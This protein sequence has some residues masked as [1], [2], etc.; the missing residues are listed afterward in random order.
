MRLIIVILLSA[1]AA[2]AQK[3]SVWAPLKTYTDAAHGVSFR[4]PASWVAGTSFGYIPTA[5][6][7]GDVEPVAGFGFDAGI[8]PESQPI[9][10]EGNSFVANFGI[11][12]SVHPSASAAECDSA[13]KTIL[14]GEETGKVTYIK[15]GG[16]TYSKH[17]ISDAAM[18]KALSGTLYESF[19]H[20]IC[21][22]F[23]TDEETITMAAFDE[24]DAK[25]MTTAA[26]KDSRSVSSYLLDVMKS[27]RIR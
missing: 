16:I 1:T 23:E 7:R 21:Y 27:V 2:C 26:V 6:S 14:D 17:R 10:I 3:G 24:D 12:Y 18:M 11:V 20:G 5:S 8:S 15:L 13:T 25:K 19:R 4:Y 9:I 22:L